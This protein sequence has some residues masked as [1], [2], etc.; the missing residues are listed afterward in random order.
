MGRAGEG[1]HADEG[2]IGHP[3]A[4]S[5]GV[6]VLGAA[7]CRAF[8]SASDSRESVRGLA[9]CQR[10]CTQ[11]QQTLVLRGAAPDPAHFGGGS[12]WRAHCMIM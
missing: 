9:A 12:G 2:D 8:R 6:P 4:R 11:V 1:L 3:C 7:F 10:Q 5:P